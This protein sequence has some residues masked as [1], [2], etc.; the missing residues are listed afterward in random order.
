MANSNRYYNRI[1]RRNVSQSYD[2]I[3]KKNRGLLN[4]MLQ[5]TTPVMTYPTSDQ[6]GNLVLVNH[7]WKMND[8]FYKLAH[9]HYG[10]SK[11]WW[12]IAWFNQTPTEAHL[13]PGDEIDI[14]FPLDALIGYYG[15]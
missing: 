15:L 14:A 6:I 1:V 8:K 9:K 3:I 4:G 7:I 5:Y 2:E 10:D 13:K 12:A 11:L